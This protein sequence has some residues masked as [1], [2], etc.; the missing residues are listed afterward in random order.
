M[1]QMG[2]TKADQLRILQAGL[3]QAE[4]DN[5]EVA[6]EGYRN[7]INGITSESTIPS[8]KNEQE[9]SQFEVVSFAEIAKDLED[10][11]YEELGHGT[12]S[13]ENAQSILNEGLRVGGPGRDTDIDSNFM[14]LANNDSNALLN[15]AENWQHNNAKFIVLYRIPF[16]YKLPMANMHGPETYKMFYEPN[17]GDPDAKSGKYSKDFAYAFLDVNTGMAYK[18][19]AYKGDLDN[20]E[21]KAEMEN[22]YQLLRNETASKIVNPDEREGFLAMAESWHEMGESMMPK[23]PEQAQPQLNPKKDEQIESAAENI[24]VTAER[25]SGRTKI[26]SGDVS[27]IYSIEKVDGKTSTVIESQYFDMAEKFTKAHDELKNDSDLRL[28]M[29]GMSTDLALIDATHGRN[30]TNGSEKTRTSL[31]EDYSTLR[32]RLDNPDTSPEEKQLISDYFDTMSG[33]ALSFLE[34]RYNPDLA[35]KDATEEQKSDEAKEKI[36][37]VLADA[38]EEVEKIKKAFSEDSSQ[39]DSALADINVLVD[40]RSTDLDE[41]QS[42]LTKLLQ[43]QESLAQSTKRFNKVNGDYLTNIVQNEEQL[44]EDSYRQEFSNVE[45]NNE[46]VQDA[47]KKV[48]NVDD[49]IAQIKTYIRRVED[50]TNMAR[51]F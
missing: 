17:D 30:F 4:E 29:S 46:Q 36:N 48:Q 5:D 6:I 43:A 24:D 39:F 23:Q 38:K 50:L 34:S 51:R 41:L 27:N 20:P 42:S 12:I 31:L 28:A 18:N 35:K 47:S 45:D 11:R 44:G 15:S 10:P 2:S 37:R 49:R 9:K 21:Q 16:E 26:A 19:N 25:D 40:G 8:E 32:A 7:A 14:P 33:N 13:A 22:K 3:K 1:H